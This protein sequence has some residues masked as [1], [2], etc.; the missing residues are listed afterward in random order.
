MFQAQIFCLAKFASSPYIPNISNSYE[1]MKDIWLIFIM[2]FGQV[3][4]NRIQHQLAPFCYL[5]LEQKL[6]LDQNFIGTLML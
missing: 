4:E 5:G 6:L 3:R 1:K 2:G